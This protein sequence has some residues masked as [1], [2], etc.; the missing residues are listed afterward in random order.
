MSY[1][2]LNSSGNFEFIIPTNEGMKSIITDH[3]TASVYIK[4]KEERNTKMEN[5]WNQ[6]ADWELTTEPT[7][8][9]G[10]CSCCKEGLHKDY[11]WSHRAPWDFYQLCPACYQHHVVES[12]KM[13]EPSENPECGCGCGQKA[14]FSRTSL[15]QYYKDATVVQNICNDCLERWKRSGEP[16]EWKFEPI[17]FAMAPNQDEPIIETDK[18]REIIKLSLDGA[19]DY[20]THS[21]FITYGKPLV[22]KGIGVFG[23]SHLTEATHSATFRFDDGCVVEIPPPTGDDWKSEIIF[24]EWTPQRSGQRKPRLWD[25][26]EDVLDISLPVF[27]IGKPDKDYSA[28]LN[29]DAA[30]M[31]AYEY[32]VRIGDEEP[33]LIKLTKHTREIKYR[34]NFKKEAYESAL[35]L[36][37]DSLSTTNKVE[38]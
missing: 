14:V 2:K 25:I 28:E 18:K 38:K 11:Y 19:E 24:D 27:E 21:S 20:L 36:I 9:G 4:Q 33:E 1:L 16:M 29:H 15:D 34:G 22:I 32:R 8:S 17:R 13:V 37:F 30:K 10:T 3:L 6:Y 12:N 5:K 26:E 31:V 23:E 35:P 7:W